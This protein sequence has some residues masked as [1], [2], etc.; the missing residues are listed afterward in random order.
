MVNDQKSQQ[1]GKYCLGVK[2][3]GMVAPADDSLNIIIPPPPHPKLKKKKNLFPLCHRTNIEM[4]LC[5]HA[6]VQAP[7]P[8]QKVQFQ[9]Y[10]IQFSLPTR[11]FGG[12]GMLSRTSLASLDF[13]VMTSLSRTAVCMRRTSIWLLMQGKLAHVWVGLNLVY[14]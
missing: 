5:V 6:S 8:P 3:N 11:F 13:F 10:R 14:K 1:R 4:F 9:L 7:H 12:P 2:H